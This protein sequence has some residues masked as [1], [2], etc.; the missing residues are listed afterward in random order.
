MKIT[1]S[2][3]AECRF[4]LA[5]WLTHSCSLPDIVGGLGPVRM[6]GEAEPAGPPGAPA[7]VGG[8]SGAS[9]FVENTEHPGKLW[10]VALNLK[11][12]FPSPRRTSG[13]EN[14]PPDFLSIL[15]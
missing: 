14:W 11:N 1:Y 12:M 2:N 15:G 5:S 8:H 6:E 9:P 4:E 10:L 3:F 7:R 13:C